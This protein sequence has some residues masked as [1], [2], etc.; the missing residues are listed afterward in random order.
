[1]RRYTAALARVGAD[2]R[3]IAS[4]KGEQEKVRENYGVTD[5]VRSMSEAA[6][7]RLRV[8][9][10]IGLR[11]SAHGVSRG[12][13]KRHTRWEQQVQELAES[14]P[15]GRAK[16]TMGKK[17]K[18]TTLAKGMDGIRAAGSGHSGW[19]WALLGGGGEDGEGEKRRGEGVQMVFL[20]A[21]SSGLVA[22]V[23]VV[24]W[25]DRSA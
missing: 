8:S 14:R 18:R 21:G 24:R 6:L 4:H 3:E 1:M 10:N 7:T 23:R 2:G 5:P 17:R 22:A 9:H 11:S 19:Q 15:K 13:M 12:K 16:Q 20:A 25:Q